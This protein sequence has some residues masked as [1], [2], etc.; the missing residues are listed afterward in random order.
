MLLNDGMEPAS[1]KGSTNS[2][3]ST[4]HSIL[5]HTHLAHPGCMDSCK[6]PHKVIAFNLVGLEHHDVTHQGSE[7]MPE[8]GVGGED[9]S[10]Q[11]DLPS[12]LGYSF[13]CETELFR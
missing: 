10:L 7:D 13:L 11:F 6:C 8:I 3:K 5:D 2:N 9:R 1:P 4:V 12:P